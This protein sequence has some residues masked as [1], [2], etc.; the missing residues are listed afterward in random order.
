MLMMIS[1]LLILSLLL[2][3]L[4]NLLIF[5]CYHFHPFSHRLDS[6]HLHYFPHILYYIHLPAPSISPLLPALSELLFSLPF[7]FILFFLHSLSLL[8]FLCSLS[9]LFLLHPLSP[10]LPALTIYPLLPALS[11]YP[12]LPVCFLSV[13]SPF[14]IFSLY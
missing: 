10:L 6:V 7:L 9:L 3:P 5:I 4:P 13:K 2:F 14:F 12:L 8:F 11:V 1:L